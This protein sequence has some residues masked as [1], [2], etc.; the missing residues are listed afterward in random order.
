MRVSFDWLKDY[1][2]IPISPGV[3]AERLTMAG[4]EVTSLTRLDQDTILEI[5][6]TPNRTDCLSITG[7]AREVAA[8]TDKK[9]K[10]PRP[11]SFRGASGLSLP[12]Q[13][14]AKSLC[15]RYVGRVIKNVKVGPSPAWLIRRLEVMGVRPVN[16]IVDITNFCLLEFGQPLHAFDLDKLQGRRIIVR[17]ACEG[18]QI[19]TIDGVRR[20]LDPTVLVIA[21]KF[22]PR[23]IAGIMGGENSEVSDTT[24]AILLESAYFDPL[25]IHN[26]SRR[27]GL[28]SQSSYRFERGV[29]LEGVYPASLRATELIKRLAGKSPKAVTVGRLIDKGKKRG[30]V[31]KVCLRYAKAG[32]VLGVEVPPAQIR[33]ILRNLQ[34]SIVRNSKESL[35]VSVPSFR[36]DITREADLIEETSRLYGYDKIPLNL[37]RLMPN[38]SY[39]GGHKLFSEATY[40]A[41][42]QILSSLGLNEIMTYSLISRQA[43]RKLDVP[44]DNIITVKNPL[45]YEQ[46]ILRPTLLAGM[47]NA[48]LTNIN[49]K[50]TNLKLFELSRI[51][52]KA[53]RACTKEVTNLCIGIAGKKS[54][55]WMRKS[56]EYCFFDLKGIVEILLNKLGVENFRFSRGQPLDFVQDGSKDGEPVEPFPA[57]IPGRCAAVM[58]GED[59]FGFLGEV[60]RE[61]LERFDISCPVYAC[62]LQL[63]KLLAH[64]R[65]EKRFVPL[66]RFPSIYRDISLIVPQEVD[67]EQIVSLVNKFGRDL[68]A[69][70]TLFDQYF[71]EQIPSGFRGLSFSIEY[72]S[73]E[74]TLTAAEVDKL[75]TQVRQALSRELAAQVR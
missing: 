48:L 60:K 63:H 32:E 6:V 61:I 5:E 69:K 33:E 1:V 75:H 16:N 30:R 71:G 19:V 31:N 2:D 11:P 62:K 41:V 15:R 14:R 24:T 73:V 26:T 51:Y 64:I 67:S 43:L 7:I 9:L 53:G 23:A 72:C 45:S 22:S 4:L 52:L 50:N 56:D 42:R 74:R 40:S 66:V 3:L 47:L 29:D 34:F 49:R 12:I 25:S 20:D 21:D 46:E 10:V 65:R 57:F 17:A 68:V 58:L 36:S 39:A 28:A 8:I 70:V 18:E 37:S 59:N 35:T 44:G 54:D 38:L 13:I 55:N 27:L